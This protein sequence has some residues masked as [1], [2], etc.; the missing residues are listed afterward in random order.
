MDGK[1]LLFK[2]DLKKRHQEK[3]QERKTAIEESFTKTSE[4]WKCHQCRKIT[5]DLLND[6][7][8]LDAKFSIDKHLQP[9]L[10]EAFYNIFPDLEASNKCKTKAQI[11][12]KE[13]LQ[14]CWRFIFLNAC[15]A[16][17]NQ[18]EAISISL[19][20]AN[21]CKGAIYHNE[22]WN[23]AELQAV[24]RSACS[25][26]FFEKR[27]GQKGDVSFITR[28]RIT[29]KFTKHIEEYVFRNKKCNGGDLS[30]DITST[31]AFEAIPLT[32]PERE[33]VVIKIRD[34][35]YHT[36]SRASNVVNAMCGRVERYNQFMRE[37][38]IVINIS[39]NVKKKIKDDLRY[40]E[41]RR[42]II[43]KT[44]NKEITFKD[45]NIEQQ[46]DNSAPTNDVVKYDVLCNDNSVIVYPNTAYIFTRYNCQRIFAKNMDKGGRFYGII[47]QQL[48][49]EI[50]LKMTINGSPVVEL[51]Y[52]AIHPSLLFS[53]IGIQPP[54]NIYV[55]DKTNDPQERK[56]MKII[57]LIAFNAPT[58][59]K[60]LRAI[61]KQY[62]DRYQVMLKDTDIKL[63]LELMC[64]YNPELEQFLFKG[65]GV[66]L[67]YT[68]SQIMDE[69]LAKLTKTGVPAIP[70]HDSVIVPEKDCEYVR[71]VMVDAYQK[72]T[73]TSHVPYITVD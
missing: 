37:Q 22:Y 66:E 71:T 53:S 60:A 59:K 56:L 70:V 52:Q 69:I 62:N 2:N 49:E 15:Q 67:Q 26:G 42:E 1:R 50:R 23:H 35:L 64:L 4:F 27:R 9:L 63:G 16:V 5:Y 55:Y 65:L 17:R 41:I 12:K 29:E 3:E 45:I 30:D 47:A 43:K 68:D 13:K 33:P 8:R 28:L 6:K 57:S 7:F 73:K 54:E 39:E 51:D 21:Y 44:D 20:K 61:R 19:D 48:P 10:L 72:I 36:P 11:K 34:N 24:I 32:R 14:N 38:E 40:S 25:C 18:D 46:Q 58:E 31:D